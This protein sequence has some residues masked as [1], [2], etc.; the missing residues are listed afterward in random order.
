M[1][2]DYYGPL[3]KRARDFED[4]TAVQIYVLELM[5]LFEFT[6]ALK[7]GHEDIQKNRVS[8]LLVLNKNLK[9]SKNTTV[10]VQSERYMEL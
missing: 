7:I 8:Q 1:I 4:E 5:R 6:L 3:L 10:T 2:N 9:V